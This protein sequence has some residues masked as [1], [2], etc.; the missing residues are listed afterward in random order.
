MGSTSLMPSTEKHRYLQPSLLWLP[1]QAPNSLGGQKY[2]MKGKWLALVPLLATQP[3]LLQEPKVV[4][5][6]Y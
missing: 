5:T 3:C 2:A 4:R 6:I 1:S